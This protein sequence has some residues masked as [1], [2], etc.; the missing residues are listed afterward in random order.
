MTTD[1]H[2]IHWTVLD[3]QVAQAIEQGAIKPATAGLSHLSA[4]VAA[5]TAFKQWPPDKINESKARIAQ[6]Q[7]A[8]EAK[9]QEQQAAQAQQQMPPAGSGMA[10]VVPMQQMQ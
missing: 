1:N 6:L 4:H 7:R 2:W 8:L 9:T 5:G 10:P 3:P